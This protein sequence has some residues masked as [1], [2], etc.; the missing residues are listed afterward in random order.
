MSNLV[1][2]LINIGNLR[3][4]DIINSFLQNDRV[5][6]VLPKYFWKAY[7]DNP[8]SIG[9]EQTISQPSTVAFMMELLQPKPGNNVLDIGFGSGWTTSILANI[10]GKKGSVFSVEI[11]HDIYQFGIKNLQKYNYKNIEFYCGSW[12]DTK[13]E[14]YD[15]ILVSAAADP[16]VPAKLATILTLKG[17][18]VIPVQSGSD[19]VIRLIVRN[20][21]DKIYQKDFPNYVFVPLV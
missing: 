5:N 18:M 16:S 3:T 1:D 19:Q 17:R 9:L 12:K 8:I 15:R 7:E 13:Q 21:N 11:L 4:P 20:T 10:V 14:K 2:Y 6:F